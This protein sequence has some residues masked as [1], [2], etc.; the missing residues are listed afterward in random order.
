MSESL[1]S[2]AFLPWLRQGVARAITSQ[3]GDASVL[4]R[5]S[6][7]VELTL[8]GQGLDGSALQAQV[9]RDVEL[10]GPGEVIGIE[11]RAIVRTDPRPWITNFEPNYLAQIEFYEEDFPWRYTPAAAD[12]SKLRLRPWIALVVLKD[13]GDPATTEFQD[14]K[15][16]AG[17]PLPFIAAKD[18]ATF[19]PPAELWAWAHVH[20][21]RGLGA[22]ADELVAKDVPAAIGRLETALSADPDIAYSRIVCPRRLEENCAYHA[23]L[24]PTFERGRLAGLGLDPGVAPFASVS[25]WVDYGGRPEPQNIPYYHRW[26]FRTGGAGDFETL[27]G[28]LK[29]KTADPRVGRRDMDVQEPG[30][31]MPG[32]LEPDLH[33]ILRLG[34]ALRAPLLTLSPDGVKEFNKYENWAKAVFPH[35]FQQKLARFI[36]L[37]DEFTVK[38][39]VDARTDAGLP[40]TDPDDVD[41]LVTS[42]IYGEWQALQH[43]LLVD[44]D[45]APLP[46]NTNWIHELNLDPRHRVAG[47]FGGDVVRKYQEEYMEAAWLQVGDVLAHNQKA[48][49]ARTWVIVTDAVHAKSIA[50]VATTPT[51]LLSLTAPLQAR[52]L[53]GGVTLKFARQQSVT[54][55]ALTSPMMRRIARPGGPLA[56]KL[57]LANGPHATTML[58]AVNAGTITAAPPKQTPTGITTVEDIAQASAGPRTFPPEWAIALV[59]RLP[60]LPVGLL[61]AAL[62]L[63]VLAFVVGALGFLFGIGAIVALAAAALFQLASRL[64]T[65]DEALG[66]DLDKP[67]AIDHLG[68]GPNFV[69][70]DAEEAG[71]PSGIGGLISGIFAQDNVAAQRFKIALKDWG[72]FAVAAEVAG[73]EPARTRLDLAVVSTSIVT[74]LKPATT[75]SRRFLASAAI[76]PHIRAQITEVFDEIKYYPRIDLPMYRPLKELGDECFVPNLNLIERDSVVALETNQNFIES[77]MVGVNHEFSRELLWRE[78]PTDQRGTY[79]R[80]FWDVASHFDPKAADADAQREKLYDIPPIHTWPRASELGEHDNRQA[81]PGEERNEIVL[82]IRGELLKKY[83]TTVV[84]AHAAKWAIKDGRIDPSQERDLVPLSAAEMTS[85][86]RTIVRTPLYE[87]KVDPDIYFFGFDLDAEEAR[88]GTGDNQTDPP[89]WFFVLKERPGEPRFGLDDARGAGQPIVSVNDIAWSDAGTKPGHHLG[90]GALATISLTPPSA[91][92]D[93]LEKKPQY[94]DDLRVVGA[95]ISAARWAYVLYQAPVMVAVHAAELLKTATD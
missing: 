7:H 1:G 91:A 20:V 13:T 6:A 48:R 60:W 76:A 59:R 42:P 17:R 11:D 10:Y 2:Y 31:N 77:Y 78:Y 9:T 93:D 18:F 84:Y 33:G 82:V 25:A 65:L 83:P 49:V 87:A 21:N 16:V 41:P 89:G 44:G 58:E 38:T 70:G 74:A 39:A 37:A 34:G 50:A 94:D 24:V 22:T 55:T 14:A 46:N 56:R 54:P 19:P 61:I 52:V 45:G 64:P 68:A 12:P 57:G 43:R 8:S 90:A 88:G 80:Q 73:R 75:I 79:F 40:P 23:F 51:R 28:L 29:W 30:S 92:R 4:L 32:I 36:N 81:N 47:G 63:I 62:V 35:P 53:T 66:A 67:E 86:P 26:Y 5:A 72:R 3:D 69:F 27:V 95:P 71:T 85:P 15:A